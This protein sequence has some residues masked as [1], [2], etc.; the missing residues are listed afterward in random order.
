MGISLFGVPNEMYEIIQKMELRKALATYLDDSQSGF[1]VG[2]RARDI[3]LK[4][5]I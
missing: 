4:Q 3:I 5:I 2:H 1:R